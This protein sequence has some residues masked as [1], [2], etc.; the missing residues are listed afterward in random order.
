[1]TV[2]GTSRWPVW[3]RDGARLTFSSE[4][5]GSWDLFEI[6]PSGAGEPQPW[7]VAPEQHVPDRR[8]YPDAMRTT[9]DKAGR[10]VIPA[11]ARDRLG[12]TPGTTLE[13]SVDETGLRLERVAPG[14][15]I[16]RI[17]KRLVARPTVSP[18]ER[19]VVDIAA[20]VE[21]ERNRWP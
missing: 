5:E 15:Q 3:T 19:P 7:L 16:V 1:M 4:R 17:G 21:E 2:A 11:A 9:I 18:D 14:P 12:L 20:L 8:G 13:V 10:L 6:A